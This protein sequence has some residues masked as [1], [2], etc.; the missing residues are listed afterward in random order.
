[1]GSVEGSIGQEAPLTQNDKNQNL[2]EPLD[3]QQREQASQQKQE[4]WEKKRGL[5]HEFMEFLYA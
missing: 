3:T 4:E 2:Y 5:S 1:L